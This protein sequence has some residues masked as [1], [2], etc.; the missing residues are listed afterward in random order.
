MNIFN[1]QIKEEEVN[2]YCENTIGI[3]SLYCGFE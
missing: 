3:D 2:S 1:D